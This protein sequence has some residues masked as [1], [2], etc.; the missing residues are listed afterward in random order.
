M[1]SS[2]PFRESI[3]RKHGR[4]Q[5]TCRDT[6]D[7]KSCQ[8]TVWPRRKHNEIHGRTQVSEQ[9][10]S[11]SRVFSFRSFRSPYPEAIKHGRQSEMHHQWRFIAG[12]IICKLKIFH[13]C[14]LTLD[15]RLKHLSSSNAERPRLCQTL[16]AC[17]SMPK[18][19]VGYKY[20]VGDKNQFCSDHDLRCICMRV[21]KCI[22]MYMYINIYM[23]IYIYVNKY[24]YIYMYI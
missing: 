18:S 11:L 20:N 16:E 24:I 14:L 19:K 12:K 22:Y 5:T 3:S 8:A 2:V 6:S 15:L 13:P 21:D 1:S 23:Y 9:I 7:A 17:H 10:Q 4:N